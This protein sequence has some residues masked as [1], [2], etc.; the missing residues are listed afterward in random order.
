MLCV[1]L[2]HGNWSA[3]LLFTDRSRLIVIFGILHT[4]I[5]EAMIPLVI[6][7]NSVSSVNGKINSTYPA[8]KHLYE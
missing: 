7:L 6:T 4:Y 5:M 1:I 8:K 2:Q 3:K